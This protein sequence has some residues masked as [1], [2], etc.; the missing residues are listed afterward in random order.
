MIPPSSGLRFDGLRLK[1]FRGVKSFRVKERVRVRTLGRFPSE[2]ERPLDFES[3]RNRP[4]GKC[5]VSISKVELL[6]FVLPPERGGLEE[7]GA[8][9]GPLA[10]PR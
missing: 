7:S 10:S 1:I 8:Y 9:D 4:D 6:E 3:L 2:D 5:S